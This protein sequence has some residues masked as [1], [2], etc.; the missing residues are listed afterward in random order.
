MHN[1]LPGKLLFK[2]VTFTHVIFALQV[3]RALL[4]LSALVLA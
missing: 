3:K 1:V 4:S 2:E